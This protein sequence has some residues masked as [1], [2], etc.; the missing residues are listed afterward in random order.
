MGRRAAATA[1]TNATP[2]DLEP[3]GT[4]IAEGTVVGRACP[5]TAPHLGR[6]GGCI[7]SR[8]YKRY[9]QWQMLVKHTTS[10]Q[11]P[12]RKAWPYGGPVELRL[13]FVLC[14]RGGR[15]NPDT[16]NLIK[17]TE[18][19]MQGVLFVNDSQV[20]RI[21]AERVFCSQTPERVEYQVIAL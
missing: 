11:K 15:S 2:I 3:T 14:K 12:R 9:Q 4:V 16:T 19:S 21:H 20:Q 5:W 6:N 18:D 7:P 1:P 13:R 17:S 10:A 8:G